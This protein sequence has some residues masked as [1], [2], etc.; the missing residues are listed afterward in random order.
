M[1]QGIELI[2]P[3]AQ[4]ATSADGHG[5]SVKRLEKVEGL[6]VGLLDNGMPHADAFLHH[7]G[8]AFE[9]RYGTTTVMRRKA[10]TARS[11][12]AELLDEIAT[13]CEAVITGFGV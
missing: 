6:R 2:N 12:G 7:I 9:E 13:S 3:V 5:S 10:Y 8:Q 1:T 4:V 11:A